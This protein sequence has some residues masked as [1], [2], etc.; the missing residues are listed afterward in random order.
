[1]PEEIERNAKVEVYED[2]AYEWRWRIRASNGLVIATSGEGYGTRG[3]CERAIAKLAEY[4]C[5][6]KV[7]DIPVWRDPVQVVPDGES[8]VG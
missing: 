1:M 4:F 6:Q 5:G 3:G 8:S 7:E 2:R